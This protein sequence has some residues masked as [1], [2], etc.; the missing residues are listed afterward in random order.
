M[1]D[2]LSRYQST[3]AAAGSQP[4]AAFLARTYNHLL[5]AVVAL[6]GVEVVLFQTGF[7]Q[8]FASLVFGKGQM[9]WLLVLGGFMLVSYL[10]NNMAAS[11][12]SS[13]K[14]YAGLGGFVIAEAVLL[15]PMLYV[16]WV[17]MSPD[18]V[19]NAAL[20]TLVAFGTL[21]AIVYYTKKDFTFLKSF[22]MWGGFLALGAIVLGAV[23]GFNLGLFFT[24][25]MIGYAGAAILYTTSSVLQ[26]YPD[27][28]HV[29]AALALFSAVMLLF[30]YVLQFVM[31]MSGE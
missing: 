17:M 11:R 30:W 4:R 1:N 26:D 2:Q 15:S 25:A 19:K 7:A 14:Q 29:A 28:F 9:A 18:V 10:F 20:F 13:A 23:T 24:V 27:D 31:S 8:A 21:T 6:V 5:G 3:A 16:A 22:I 12:G